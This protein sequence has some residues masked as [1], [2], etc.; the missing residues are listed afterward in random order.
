MSVDNPQKRPGTNWIPGGGT[1]DKGEPFKD[2]LAG[3]GTSTNYP[4]TSENIVEDKGG[5][6]NQ[7]GQDRR[8]YVL[9]DSGRNGGPIQDVTV[10][11]DGTKRVK[12]IG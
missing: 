10:A 9:D 3:K 2:P 6:P 1:S 7:E 5:S 11:P 4:L 12:D 8:G